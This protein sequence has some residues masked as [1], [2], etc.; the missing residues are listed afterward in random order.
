FA[1]AGW[2]GFFGACGSLAAGAA[3]ASAWR[4]DASASAPKPPPALHRKSR[5]VVTISRCGHCGRWEE[6]IA[7]SASGSIEIEEVVTVEQHVTEIGQRGRAGLGTAGV[8]G[9]PAQEARAQLPLP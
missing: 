5:R 9:L 1:R 2:C 3:A 4:R 6:S 7:V 8:L